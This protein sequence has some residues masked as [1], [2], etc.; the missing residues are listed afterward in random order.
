MIVDVVVEVVV[1]VVVGGLWKGGERIDSAAHAALGP[2]LTAVLAQRNP[3]W[4]AT[5]SL[6][7]A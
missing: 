1:E 3:K 4:W 7:T 6:V 2:S 5:S